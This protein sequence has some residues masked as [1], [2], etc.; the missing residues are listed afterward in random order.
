MKMRKLSETSSAKK[1]KVQQSMK[2]KTATIVWDCRE[3]LLIDLKEKNTVKAFHSEIK[4]KICRILIYRIY[5]FNLSTPVH[6][7][8]VAKAYLPSHPDIQED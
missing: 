6:S 1:I 2:K 8:I 5:H 7:T 3:T 4:G